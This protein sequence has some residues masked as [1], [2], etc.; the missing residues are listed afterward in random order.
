MVSLDKSSTHAH[1]ALVHE[2]S[3]FCSLQL[4]GS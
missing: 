3:A 1:G 2:S 4:V